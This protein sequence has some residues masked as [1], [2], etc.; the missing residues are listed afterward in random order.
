VNLLLMCF[1][2]FT[3]TRAALSTS[4]HCHAHSAQTISVVTLSVPRLNALWPK[5]TS[6]LTRHNVPEEHVSERLVVDAEQAEQQWEQQR[7]IQLRSK[8]R[9]PGVHGMC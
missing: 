3:G 6:K 9:E 5:M 2:V 4:S 7:R 8:G 1:I